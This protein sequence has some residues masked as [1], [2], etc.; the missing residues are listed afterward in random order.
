MANF[1]NPVTSKVQ[2]SF[3]DLAKTASQL[4]FVS[5]ALGKYISEIEDAFKSINLGVASW[6]TIEVAP[7]QDGIV[8]VRRELGYDKIA[9]NWC[10]ALRSMREAEWSDEPF[11]YE[12]WTF[13]EGTRW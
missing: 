8:W 2:E 11:D 1:T 5:D 4:N 9:K 12:L 10:I 6:V 13:N 7:T 3:R